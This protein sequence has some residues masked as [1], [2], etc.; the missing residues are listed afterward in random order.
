[1]IITSPTYFDK[2]IKI[3]YESDLPLS[4]E[5]S[6]MSM[7]QEQLRVYLNVVFTND[8]LFEPDLI[9]RTTDMPLKIL[10]YE[11]TIPCLVAPT[12]MSSE[13]IYLLSQKIKK[14]VNE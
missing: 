12:D 3:K 11:E 13:Q 7:L 1:M 4:I 8:L 6:Y 2:E 10:T 9:I 5:L 14:L